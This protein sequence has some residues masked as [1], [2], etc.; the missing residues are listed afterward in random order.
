M[1]FLKMLSR[2]FMAFMSGRNGIDQLSIAILVCSLV[3]QIISSL[4]GSSVLILASVALY[5]WALFRVFSRKNP[6]REIENQ[7]FMAW[8]TPKFTKL[9]QF[10][11]RQK[12]RKQYKYFKCPQCGALLRLTRGAGE[13]DVCCPKCQNRFKMKA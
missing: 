2:R 9:R 10:V 12:L 7:K 8:F 1:S 6:Q 11:L 5:G 4:L 13:K 3:L